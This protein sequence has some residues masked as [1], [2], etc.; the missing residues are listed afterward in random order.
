MK[1]Q[2]YLESWNSNYFEALTN[3]PINN[4]TTVNIAFGSFNFDQYS[5]IGGMSLTNEQVRSVIANVRSRGGKCNLSFGGANTQYYLSN[6][7][8]WSDT[9]KIA[10]AIVNVINAYAFDGCDLDIEETGDDAFGDQILSIIKG[11]KAK[12]SYITISLTIPAQGWNTYWQDL[13]INAAP[14]VDV[15][16][17]MEYDLWL[18]TDYVA[19]IKSDIQDYYIGQWGIPSNKIC[20]GLMPGV[21]DK[22][23]DLTLAM[24][25]D[26]TT[27]A[28]TQNLAGI[29]LWDMNRDYAGIDSNSSFAYTNAVLSG[30]TK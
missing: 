4:T 21:D 19:Q 9:D 30:L 29:M 25:Q 28:K 14:I 22:G 7:N 16:N 8:L 17:F 6:S 15:I 11:I 23:A 1:F 20:M 26:L 13:A 10:S 5:N 27:W 18:G 12:A 24:T 3:Q 2:T